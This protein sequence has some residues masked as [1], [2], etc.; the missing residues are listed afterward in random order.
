MFRDF[1]HRLSSRGESVPS[2]DKMPMPRQNEPPEIHFYVISKY[3]PVRESVVWLRDK[4]AKKISKFGLIRGDPE[5]HLVCPRG[6]AP[7]ILCY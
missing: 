7:Y 2:A 1:K 3:R 4:Q 6:D 5:L